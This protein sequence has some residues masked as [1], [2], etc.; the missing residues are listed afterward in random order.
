MPN[1]LLIEGPPASGKSAELRDLLDAGDLDI[2]LEFT[3]IWAALKGYRRDPETGHYPIRQSD[4]PAA[5]IAA[6]MMLAGLRVS[7]RNNLNVGVTTGTSGRVE[8]YRDI[9]ADELAEFSVRTIDPGQ[10]VVA[11]RL[12]RSF[13]D[14]G[15]GGLRDE[16]L[17][18]MGRWYG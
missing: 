16:C 3:P 8:K 7:L 10:D 14:P 5:P 11:G 9:A 6:A 18:A 15:T 17:D 4:D 1:L 13:P 2:G 12:A